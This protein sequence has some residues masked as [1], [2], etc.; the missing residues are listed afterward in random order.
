MDLAFSF[1]R[2][3]RRHPLRHVVQGAPGKSWVLG[4]RSPH[5]ASCSWPSPSGTRV[6]LHHMILPRDSYSL[7]LG[8]RGRGETRLDRTPSTAIVH[9]SAA[10]RVS[11]R[12]THLRGCEAIV[13]ISES[14]DCVQYAYTVAAF[15]C[16]RGRDQGVV[17][18]RRSRL[19][20]RNI[21]QG[22]SH[23]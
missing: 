18:R 9:D 19:G 14:H 1:P 6:V 16:V 23:Q 2:R 12:V 13:G 17:S 10:A 20:E 7:G 21:D 15:G 4:A 11:R 8:P 3:T 5:P 22:A